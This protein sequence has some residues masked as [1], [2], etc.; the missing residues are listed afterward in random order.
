MSLCSQLTSQPGQPG[1]SAVYPP[2]SF[3]FTSWLPRSKRHPGPCWGSWGCVFLWRSGWPRAGLGLAATEVLG[4]AV[5]RG[6]VYPNTRTLGVRSTNSQGQAG[7]ETEFWHLG[8]GATPAPKDAELPQLEAEQPKAGS[9]ETDI[10][11]NGGPDPPHC[12]TAPW[13][14]PRANW[15]NRSREGHAPD[16]VARGHNSAWGLGLSPTQQKQVRGT[17]ATGGSHLP[18][19]WPL[20]QAGPCPTL[21]PAYQTSPNHSWV[22]EHGVTVVMSMGFGVSV[23]STARTR[24]CGHH[25]PWGS[26]LSS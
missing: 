1:S 9:M 11:P 6:C 22:G 13:L 18:H 10:P 16:R 8:P 20:D 19:P 3:D 2:C 12:R 23:N 15:Q 7:G 5:C 4:L 26:S 17:E 14:H 24:L 21:G 25:T